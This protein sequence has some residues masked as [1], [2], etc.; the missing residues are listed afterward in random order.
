[1]IAIECVIIF[2]FHLPL[3]LVFNSFFCVHSIYCYWVKTRDYLLNCSILTSK[4]CTCSGV[5]KI[6]C[7]T[8]LCQFFLDFFF[9]ELT[10][11]MIW[12]FQIKWYGNICTRAVSIKIKSFF[13]SDITING[14]WNLNL[15]FYTQ[16]LRLLLLWCNSSTVMKFGEKFA[17]TRF[18][19]QNV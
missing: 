18:H 15:D 16:S 10:F 4:K 17:R 2:Y 7:Q 1:M 11:Q 8:K 13:G 9:V 19:K 3:I 12:H 6:H 5:I 14:Q